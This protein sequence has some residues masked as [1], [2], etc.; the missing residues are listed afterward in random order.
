MW[1]V[2]KNL[3]FPKVRIVLQISWYEKVFIPKNSFPNTNCQVLRK[4]LLVV[5]SAEVRFHL[6][7]PNIE[8]L[9][10]NIS[11]EFFH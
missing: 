5:N 10:K 6:F 3:L 8:S 7:S 2:C 9:E 11:G 4:N 1:V